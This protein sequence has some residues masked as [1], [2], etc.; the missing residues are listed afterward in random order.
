VRLFLNSIAYAEVCKIAGLPD[1][2]RFGFVK[3][4]LIT[5]PETVREQEEKERFQVYKEELDRYSIDRQNVI[6][7]YCQKLTQFNVVGS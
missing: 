2:H 3:Y 7:L 1:D 6:P 4:A 5:A